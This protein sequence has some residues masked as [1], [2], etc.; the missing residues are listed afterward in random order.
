MS[1]QTCRILLPFA[2]S[3]SFSGLIGCIQPSFAQNSSHTQQAEARQRL[4][5]EERAT[6][7][8]QAKQGYNREERRQLFREC[9]EGMLSAS[10]SPITPAPESSMANPAAVQATPKRNA[11][12]DAQIIAE[13]TGGELKATK[14]KYYVKDCE[15][16]VEYEA[17]VVDL[18][19]D[20]QPEVFTLEFGGICFGQLGAYMNLYIK[21]NQG[22]WQPQFGFDG[23]YKVLKTKNQGYP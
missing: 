3:L 6:C 8:A 5:P 10:M 9:R 23:F 19:S 11:A 7:R 1:N 18:N 17:K 4:T 14:G 21:D 12:T 16:W 15:R 22:Q 20:G 2:L 13:A